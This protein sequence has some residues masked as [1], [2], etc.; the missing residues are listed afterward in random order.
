MADAARGRYTRKSLRVDRVLG[1][2]LVRVTA[3]VAALTQLF[4][5]PSAVPAYRVA[6]LVGAAAVDPAA[7]PAQA[8]ICPC[9]N[10]TKNDP[11][12]AARAGAHAPSAPVP[13]TPRTPPLRAPGLSLADSARR[14]AAS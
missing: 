6:L 13:D 12:A 4:A 2:V 10:D 11:V 7:P 5:A 1:A 14:L 8:A 9:T 3:G